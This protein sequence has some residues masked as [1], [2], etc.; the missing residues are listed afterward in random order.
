MKK[1]QRKLKYH[2]SLSARELYWLSKY[3]GD[4]ACKIIQAFSHNL[5]TAMCK[6]V[7]SGIQYISGIKR[8]KREL[9][10]KTSA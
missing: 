5:N 3:V 1:V 6:S 7:V 8:R 9:E 10:N 2:H 4:D